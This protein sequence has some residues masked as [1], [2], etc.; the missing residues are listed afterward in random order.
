M[1]T[2]Y[3]LG[4]NCLPPG[5]ITVM[6][7]FDTAH[8]NCSCQQKLYQVYPEARVADIKCGGDFPFL[9]YAEDVNLHLQVHLR[10]VGCVPDTTVH[11]APD[12]HPDEFDDLPEPQPLEALFEAHSELTLSKPGP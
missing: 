5:H 3:D 1:C 11:A 7:S 8:N 6:N 9:A 12:D 2:P 10:H 4:S